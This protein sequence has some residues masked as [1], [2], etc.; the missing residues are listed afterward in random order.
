MHTCYLGFQWRVHPQG[1][2][3]DSQMIHMLFRFPMKS[4]PPKIIA[5]MIHKID[6]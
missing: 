3:L 1:L 6:I 5:Q 2:Y 4:P